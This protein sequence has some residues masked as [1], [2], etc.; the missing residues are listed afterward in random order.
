MIVPTH[1]GSIDERLEAGPT[2][3]VDREGGGRDR[4][5]HLKTNMTSKVGRIR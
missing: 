5:T 2:Q 1:V 3:P 4:D